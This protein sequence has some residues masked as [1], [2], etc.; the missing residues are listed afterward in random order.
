MKN[1]DITAFSRSKEIIET[2]T[3]NVSLHLCVAGGFH[4]AILRTSEQIC[5]QSEFNSSR[6]IGVSFCMIATIVTIIAVAL[7]AIYNLHGKAIWE[8]LITDI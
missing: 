7:I 6:S 5:E 1:I 2:R 4:P 8:I 3:E